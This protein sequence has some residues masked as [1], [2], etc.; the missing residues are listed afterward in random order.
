MHPLSFIDSIGEWL[1]DLIANRITTVFRQQ[2]EKLE[3][4]MSATLDQLA[5]LTTSVQGLHDEVST[6][7]TTLGALQAQITDLTNKVNSGADIPEVQAAIQAIQSTVDDTKT[8]LEGALNPAP[9][10]PPAP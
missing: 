7:V 6:A 5:A 2:L 4:Q 10:T 3:F 9:A 1:A 8:Q